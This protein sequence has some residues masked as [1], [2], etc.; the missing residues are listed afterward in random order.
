MHI[1]RKT[2]SVVRPLLGDIATILGCWGVILFVVGL[3]FS[4]FATHLLPTPNP[5][6]AEAV[7]REFWNFVWGRLIPL[8]LSSLTLLVYGFYE[9][10]KHAKRNHADSRFGW[11]SWGS[12]TWTK[13]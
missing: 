11:W 10:L 1:L 8:L 3:P 9:S 12:S 7:A 13:E 6:S 4:Y 2:L 5:P